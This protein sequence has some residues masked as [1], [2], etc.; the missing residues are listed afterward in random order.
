MSVRI[1][2]FYFFFLVRSTSRKKNQSLHLVRLF[3]SQRNCNRNRGN[4]NTLSSVVFFS[5]VIGF[6]TSI[7]NPPT[8]F[9]SPDETELTVTFQFHFFLS[10]VAGEF[11]VSSGVMRNCVIG[12]H[13]RRS[14][15]LPCHG[16]VSAASILGRFNGSKAWGLGEAVRRLP[17]AQLIKLPSFPFPPP[18]PSSVLVEGRKHDRSA[19]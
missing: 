6:S 14:Q 9:L 16:V 5:V 3:F 7:K 1:Y 11:E 10:L 15:L 18:P 17:E 19:E 8:Q 4:K 13:L 12:T 2:L